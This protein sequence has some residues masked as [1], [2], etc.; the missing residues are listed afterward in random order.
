MNNND[1]PSE[2]LTGV[3]EGLYSYPGNLDPPNGFTATL[4]QFGDSVTGTVHEVGQTGVDQ[5]L[6]IHAFL[7]GRRMGQLVSFTKTYDVGAESD[8]SAPV[9][10][11]GA[12][13]G[14]GQEIEGR[15]TIQGVWSG[16]FLMVRPGRTVA[17]AR[18]AALAKV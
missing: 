15:W 3:W 4:L 16:K 13:S 1:G 7:D 10:Y 12:V 5:G 14:D 11:E 18:R 2:S 6:R 17:V 9:V 8:Y